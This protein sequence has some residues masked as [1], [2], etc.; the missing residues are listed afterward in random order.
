MLDGIHMYLCRTGHIYGSTLL[1]L[2]CARAILPV[3][4]VFNACSYVGTSCNM[5]VS[6]LVIA[7]HNGM[8]MKEVIQ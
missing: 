4:Y 2:S 7:E 8:V 1:I 3:H 5:L 6:M